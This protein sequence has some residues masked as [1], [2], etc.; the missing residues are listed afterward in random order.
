LFDLFEDYLVEGGMRYAFS[1]N[2][3]EFFASIENRVPR[4]DRKYSFQRQGLT[5][6]G[7]FSANK[8]I[9]HQVKAEYKYPFNEV[10]SFRPTINIRNDRTIALSTDRNALQRPDTYTNWVGVKLEF[11]F[12]N[13][14]D[15]GL[16]LYNG[17]R[18]KVFFERYQ[19]IARGISDIN[20]VGLDFRHYQK[21]HRD[22][23][24]ASRIAGS[25]SFGNRKLVYYLGGVDNWFTLAGSDQEPDRQRFD[26]STRIDQTQNYYFQALATNMRGFQQNVRNGNNFA[27][28]NNEI[29]F[30]VIKYFAKKPI[31][32]EFWGNLQVIG[33]GDVGTA[34]T[35]QSPFSEE[36]TF[37][38]V[39]I[40]DGP[41]TIRLE[42]KINPIIGSYGFGFR[43]KIWGY[44]GRLDYAWGVEDGLIREPRIHLSFGLDF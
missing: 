19:E 24:W 26:F 20:I 40:V 35:G 34:W 28:I 5:S 30:P 43:S 31:K 39:E 14:I 41:L 16:N 27:V 25:S 18:W 29:R 42:N 7:N 13:V 8:T 15:K 38:T 6:F 3:T 11:V 12:D 1:S 32:S 17:T 33:F 23:I 10:I 36:N 9:I 44:F 21:I 22:I 2:N 4:M 37:N